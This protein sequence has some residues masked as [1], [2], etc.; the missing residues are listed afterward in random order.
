M[1]QTW[2]KTSGEH[3][4]INF[5]TLRRLNS[6]IVNAYTHD[7]LQ[8]GVS[9]YLE[10]E[11]GIDGNLALRALMTEQADFPDEELFDIDPDEAM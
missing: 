11:Y 8:R 6:D 2:K 4:P 3:E 7:H 10:T 9:A 5:Q 1:F